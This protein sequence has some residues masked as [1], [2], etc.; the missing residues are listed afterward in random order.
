M[1]NEDIWNIRN[2]WQPIFRKYMKCHFK[3]NME[4]QC[5]TRIYT[6][7]KT[8]IDIIYTDGCSVHFTCSVM[9]NSLWPHGLQHFSPPCPSPTPWV[10]W[11][12]QTHVHGVSD[13]IQP[14][15]PLWSPS[16]PAFN[17]SQYQGLFQW[18]SSL[19]QVAKVLEFQ[20]QHQSFQ[21]IFRTD[22]LY[23]WLV[24]SPCSPRDSQES[25]S[26]PQFKN[27]NSSVLSF[28]YSLIL[29]SIH[30]YWRN[31]SFD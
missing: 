9:S 7:E 15:H 11:V 16:P 13:A 27:I 21:W 24:G 26:T 10:T 2:W 31:H 29:I 23:D 12:T 14:P 5:S 4:R 30:D 19:H 25:S 3:I 20:L 8:Q 18:V 22:F 17:L 28:L 1:V 6:R